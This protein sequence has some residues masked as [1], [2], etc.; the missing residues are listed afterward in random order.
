MT[1]SRI[2]APTTPRVSKI[3]RSL[4]GSAIAVAFVLLAHYTVGVAAILSAWTYLSLNVWIPLL[5]A[6]AS[7]YAIRAER[8]RAHLSAHSRTQRNLPRAALYL[9]TLRHNLLNLALPMRAGEWSLPLM[10]R[11]HFKIPFAEGSAGLV[12]L[13]LLDL[14]ALL[15]IV[16]LATSALIL[17]LSMT[18]TLPPFGADPRAIDENLAGAVN[19]A[20]SDTAFLFDPTLLTGPISALLI[21]G[22]MILWLIGLALI[23]RLPR[24][25]AA[26]RHNPISKRNTATPSTPARNRVHRRVTTLTQTLRDRLAAGLPAAGDQLAIWRSLAWTS[27]TW[28]IK[29]LALGFLASAML[30]AS[31]APASEPAALFLIALVAVCA[32]EL[33]SVLPIHAPFGLG[34]YAAGLVAIFTLAGIP[35]DVALTAAT[36]THLAFFGFSGLISIV[37]FLMPLAHPRGPDQAY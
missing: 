1:P 21:A 10:L 17:S 13:R 15:G 20:H 7:T 26:E 22:L 6:L 24:W 35:F 4:I 9:I 14:H 18:A 16:I 2:F 3:A 11:E 36:A 8:L 30:I 27:A 28:I 29:L 34:T 25:F 19:G 23:T 32:A 37:A 12:W 31:G 5:I 33:T